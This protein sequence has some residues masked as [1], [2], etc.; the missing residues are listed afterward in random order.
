[1]KPHYFKQEA[2]DADDVGLQEAIEKGHVP[3]TCLWSGS[4]VWLH[5]C[6]REDPCIGCAGP[7]EKCHGR[8]KVSQKKGST[9]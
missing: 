2:A 3:P 4:A 8:P 5:V 1:M 9:P 7:R 6:H